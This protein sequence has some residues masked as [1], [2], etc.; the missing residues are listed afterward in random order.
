MII[1]IGEVV[2]DIF[3]DKEVLGGAPINVA[4]HLRSLN[5]DAGIITRVGSDNLGILTLSCLKKL[6]LGVSWVQVDPHLPT[7][8][9][10]VSFD[11]QHEPHFDI[12]APAAWDNIELAAAL[13]CVE[14]RKFSLVYG[15]LGQRNS[16]SRAAIR[17]LWDQADICFYD[18][19]LRPPFTTGDLV[20]DSMSAA[21]LVKMNEKELEI[22]AAWAQIKTKDKKSIAE[23][24]CKRYDLVALI[25]TEGGSG[26]WLVSQ[27]ESFERPAEKV[28]VA[29]TVGAGDAFFASVIGG[30]LRKRPWPEVLE[31]ASKRGGYVA[32]Q[33]GATPPMP[34]F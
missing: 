14:G 24:L 11:D 7:G 12:V 3:P 25:V 5:F 13:Q 21:D 20:F 26:S 29:D 28:Q 30:Y 16:Q 32:S 15:T 18:V 6:G 8:R 1:S 9:V 22:V 34:E 19:N 27:G 31:Q 23:E 33:H 17:A 2:W 4:Y 10:N